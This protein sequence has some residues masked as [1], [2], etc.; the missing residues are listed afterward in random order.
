M[1][2]KNDSTVPDAMDVYRAVS[3][4]DLQFVGFKDVGASRSTLEELTD[5]MHQDGRTVFLEVVSTSLSDELA[6]IEA[7][8]EVGVDYVLGGT[9]VE[10]A[11][12]MFAGTSVHYCPFPGRVVGHPS[13][14][15]GT[16]DEIA[17][18][19]RR[20]TAVPGVHGVDLLAYRNHSVDPAA[21]TAAVAVASGGPVIAAGSVDSEE[22]IRALANAGA[23]AFTIGGAIFQGQLPGAPSIAAQIAWTL[24]VARA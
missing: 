10:E 20:L 8:I 4:T 22:R 3:D 19:A 1:L 17:E 23:W 2:T 21:L 18:H 11:V 7:A 13:V 14:L 6:S 9:H 16:I 24:D 5:Q 12:P 15:E